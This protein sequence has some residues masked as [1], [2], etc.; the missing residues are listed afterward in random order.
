MIHKFSFLNNRVHHFDLHLSMGILIKVLM[1]S[2]N[3]QKYQVPFSLGMCY[4]D[5]LSCPGMASKKST[6]VYE[7]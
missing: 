5:N 2:P 3:K 7:N 4:K 6:Y 1:W